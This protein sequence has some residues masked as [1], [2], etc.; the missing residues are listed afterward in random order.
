MAG[1]TNGTGEFDFAK[2]FSQFSQFKMPGV[3]ATSLLEAQRKNFEAL[4]AAGKRNHI[5]KVP[6]SS[7]GNVLAAAARS[8]STASPTPSSSSA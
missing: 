7:G 1:K 4:S 5:S 2:M 3:D 8:T 6:V